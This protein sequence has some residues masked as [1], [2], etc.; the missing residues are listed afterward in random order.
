M[1]SAV[2]CWRRHRTGISPI[3]GQ[4]NLT[5]P[6]ASFRLAQSSRDRFGELLDGLVAGLRAD[7]EN[8]VDV[9]LAGAPAQLIKTEHLDV[10]ILG[11]LGGVDKLVDPHLAP[12]SPGTAGKHDPLRHGSDLRE[13]ERIGLVGRLDLRKQKTCRLFAGHER[14]ELRVARSLVDGLALLVLPD[15]GERLV[16]RRRHR[17]RIVVVRGG[18]IGGR[19][20]LYRI[21]RDLRINRE[22]RD[23]GQHR[24]KKI[25]HIS[26]TFRFLLRC[27]SAPHL[28]GPRLAHLLVDEAIRR[29]IV[30]RADGDGI[31]TEPAAE[32]P[33][34][35]SEIEQ[36]AAAETVAFVEREFL[37]RADAIDEVGILGRRLG[38]PGKEL[39]DL[40]LAPEALVVLD[41]QGL[42]AAR[43]LVDAHA[44]GTA[45]ERLLEQRLV[46]I[47]DDFGAVGVGEHE[48][49][50]A[51]DRLGM[52]LR[53]EVLYLDRAG[54]VLA[55]DVLDRIK[56]MLRHIAK[57]AGIVVPIAAEGRADA[58]AVVGLPRSRTEPHVIV[59]AGR[60]RFDPEARA[61]RPAV[62][63]A[64]ALAGAGDALDGTVAE[65][66]GF[67]NLLDGL[68]RRAE[69]VEIVLIAEPGVE[70]E[71]A[72]LGANDLHH[73]LAF[74]DSA[75]HGLFA[76][77]VLAGVGG[78]HAL[79]AVPMGRSADVCDVDIL[80]GK[81]FHE[82]FVGLD[83]APAV[84][85][86]LGKALL[87]AILE[88]IAHADEARTA[89][90]K[91]VGA[92][93]DRTE[94]DER[95]GELVGRRGRAP[96]HFRR[97][98]VEC[99][100]GTRRLQKRPS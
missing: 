17:G 62:L 74:A 20:R 3:R 71:D 92:A 95:A 79:D 97:D 29:R 53:A 10:H 14:C 100:D 6:T 59:E 61:A 63:P 85:L 50:E 26:N 35:D 60:Q 45:Q 42:A 39:E 98:E 84:L 68:D 70:A 88:R 25:L 46:A 30:D 81:Q 34:D 67:D 64:E 32:A 57:P 72:L 91:M 93:G 16:G 21:V 78:H 27:L 9:V 73:A 54:L 12:R 13:H 43:L 89:E 8:V 38:K 75:R 69:A 86:G 99:T 7:F 65:K 11:I 28:S 55:E 36:R 44:V 19:D 51:A 87:H 37:A 24:Q 4:A 52:L 18:R 2:R 66:A 15:G 90:R 48:A 5:Q 56:I 82:V 23:R 1:L 83:L 22:D 77:D 76:P 96:E 80:V 31:E 49:V 41:A 58:M 47:K 94:A 33:R 40:L